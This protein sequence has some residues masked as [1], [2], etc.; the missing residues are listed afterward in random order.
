MGEVFQDSFYGELEIVHY[1][2]FNVMSINEIK[3][4]LLA[5]NL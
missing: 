3:V 1:C 5:N 2:V 4:N